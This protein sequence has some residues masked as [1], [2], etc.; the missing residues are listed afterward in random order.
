M[1]TQNH[2]T[3]NFHSVRAD[4]P[5]VEERLWLA[6]AES[7][8]YSVHTLDALE[9]YIHFRTYGLSEEGQA[10]TPEMQNDTKERF[11]N[12]IKAKPSEIAFI[13]STTDGE[14]I[15]LAGLGISQP[16]SYP[17]GTSRS[18]QE[19]MESTNPQ[20]RNI[21]ID[22]LHFEASKYLYTAL[23]RAGQIELRII[24]HQN[25]QIDPANVEAAIDENTVLVSV[26]LVSQVN[27]FLADVKAI[28][29]AA[30]AHGAYVYADIIQGA[31]CVP[32]DV[33]E[34]GIDFAACNTYKWL[35]GDFGI[36]FL[37]VREGL[38]EIVQPS[39]YSL[40]QVESVNDFDYEVLP[41]AARYEGSGIS[42]LSGIC[43]YQG[44]K[45]LSTLG[46]EN[47][48]THV[49]PLTERLQKE[50]PALGYCPIT[51]PD[52]PTPIVSFL[53]ANVE[54]TQAKLDRAFGH[55]VVSFRE[56][57]W[58]N[59]EGQREMVK[60]IRL[61]VSFYNNEADIDKFL[62]ALD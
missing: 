38:H 57:Y 2:L 23:T 35:M 56:W 12:L 54:E 3:P 6:A 31:G 41:G 25:W 22:D 14:N 16:M 10:F 28:S 60:G 45:Y 13:Q 61:G 24:H 51:P 52:T 21:V 36:G 18:G 27:G 53:P 9:R 8:P 33:E 55:Q 19:H 47:I 49:K 30:H 43:I 40:R 48:C 58:T 37:Y 1:S 42:N 39:R 46:V 20:N 32:I 50:M 34:M 11:A 26:A 17:S 4:F 62:N 7:H 29:Q 44:M 5:R 15:V 59:E